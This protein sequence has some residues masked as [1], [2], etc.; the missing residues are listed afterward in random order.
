MVELSPPP[1][2]PPVQVLPNFVAGTLAHPTGH[3]LN[4]VRFC[5]ISC[6][7]S[8]A[9]WQGPFVTH[10]RVGP[11]LCHGTAASSGGG[12]RSIQPAWVS[13]DGA[14]LN[15]ARGAATS[16]ELV[17]TLPRSVSLAHRATCTTLARRFL[18][19]RGET[20]YY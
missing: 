14:A 13:R 5:H 18:A 17:L 16:R 6:L 11:V 20:S 8:L 1:L 9:A 3:I 4:T 10:C 7:V 15:D 19:W 2:D 12:G